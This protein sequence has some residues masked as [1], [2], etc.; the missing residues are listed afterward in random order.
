MVGEAAVCGCR[1]RVRSVSG[2]IQ[3]LPITTPERFF[4][5]SLCRPPGSGIA[6]LRAACGK[7]PSGG[8]GRPS[9]GVARV[10]RKQS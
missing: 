1:Q 3:N 7:F 10:R 9:D 6:P 2:S 5:L 4:T 8:N